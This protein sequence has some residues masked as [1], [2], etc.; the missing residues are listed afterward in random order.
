MLLNLAIFLW[1]GAA[2]PWQSFYYS[3]LVPIWRLVILGILI[4]LFRRIPV[5]LAL[6]KGIH[7][8]Q[9]K[10]DI[11]FTGYFGPIGVS[12]VF[13]LYVALQFLHSVVEQ[14]PDRTD[15]VQLS[16]II[17]IVVWF[18]VVCSIVGFGP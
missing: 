12:A 15:L 17:T 7:Q 13:Y 2:C 16:E 3:D 14:Q 6:Y 5:V 9:T 18:L 4:L 8:V 1:F 11:L 10:Q